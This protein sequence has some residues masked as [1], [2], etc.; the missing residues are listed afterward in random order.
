MRRSIAIDAL[1]ASCSSRVLVQTPVTNFSKKHFEESCTGGG[2][3]GW[4]ERHGANLC[5]GE[6]AD[7]DP[8][9]NMPK[10]ESDRMIFILP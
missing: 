6:C 10:S 9:I 4:K 7:E 3:T 2:G 5:M 8:G 1:G